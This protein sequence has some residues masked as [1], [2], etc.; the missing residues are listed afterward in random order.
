MDLPIRGEIY[1]SRRSGQP[2]KVA[3]VSEFTVFMD[4]MS[5]ERPD[6]R[7]YNTDAHRYCRIRQLDLFYEKVLS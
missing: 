3:C 4:G 5:G 1:K 6:G 2:F 7:I